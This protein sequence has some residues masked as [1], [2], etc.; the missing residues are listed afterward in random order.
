MTELY[1]LE[2]RSLWS[3]HYEGTQEA[4]C[5]SSDLQKNRNMELRKVIV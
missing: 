2:V 5:F 4:V 3:L 1:A